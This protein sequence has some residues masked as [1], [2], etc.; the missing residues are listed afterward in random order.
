MA[1][2]NIIVEKKEGI[3]KITLNRPKALNAI[4]ETTL[5]DLLAAVEDIEKD[6][7]VRVVILTGAGRAFCAGADLTFVKGRLGHPLLL[8]QY[9]RLFH[10]AANAVENLSKPVIAAVN[11]FALAGGLEFVQACDLAIVSDQAQLGDQHANYGLMPGGGGTQRLPRLIG[12]RKAKELLYTGDW[13]APAEAERIG[14]VNKVVPADKLEETAMAL[15]KKIAEKSP[16]GIKATKMAV[17]RGM[18]TDLATGLELEI[19]AILHHFTSEDLAEG[20]KAFEERRKPVFKG[21]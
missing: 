19:G 17:N 15:A 10:K 21:K 16:L 14:L 7:S 2:T 4:D 11:G 1:Y 9:L 13:L 3:A 18:Q 20:I 8:E 12:I 5:L 6:G